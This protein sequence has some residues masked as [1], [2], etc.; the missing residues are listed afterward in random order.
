MYFNDIGTTI[1]GVLLLF[2]KTLQ[3][4]LTEYN[5]KTNISITVEYK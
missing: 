2:L 3:L 4:V 1:I 5:F